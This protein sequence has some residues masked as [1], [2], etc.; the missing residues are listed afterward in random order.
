MKKI[1]FLNAIRARG[2][3]GVIRGL[4]S[5]VS[6]ISPAAS[7]ILIRK[8]DSFSNYVDRSAFDLKYGTITTGKILHSDYLKTK[9]E[10]STIIWYEPCPVKHFISGVEQCHIYTPNYHFYDIGS[11]LG[12]IP[13]LAGSI[14]FQR[15][16]GIELN[17]ELHQLAKTNLQ[18]LPAK[19]SS[20]INFANEDALAFEFYPQPSVFFLFTPFTGFIMENFVSRIREW[21]K[22]YDGIDSTLIYYGNNLENINIITRSL[23]A[24]TNIQL[25]MAWSRPIQY[26]MQAFNF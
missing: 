12:R 13:I 17:S 2:P 1:D 15:A 9:D 10:S 3:V 4:A 26:R 19:L 25:P 7:N 5:R 16:T 6:I 20:R 22:S 18:K 21:R 24:P 8:I 11:G 14:G 23:G